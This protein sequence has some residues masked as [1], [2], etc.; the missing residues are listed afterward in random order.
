[1]FVWTLY[2]ISKVI[3][4]KLEQKE[5]ENFETSIKA[6]KELFEDA[7]KIDPNLAN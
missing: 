2:E 6:V 1:M 4:I 7:V 3:E 5:R